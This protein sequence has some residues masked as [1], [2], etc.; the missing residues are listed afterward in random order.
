VGS[1]AEASLSSISAAPVLLPL[2]CNAVPLILFPQGSPYVQGLI[3]TGKQMFH[4][5]KYGR[6]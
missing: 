4:S 2:A 1:F 6:Q 3:E 5:V